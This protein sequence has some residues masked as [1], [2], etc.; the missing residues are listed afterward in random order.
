[1]PS[2]KKSIRELPFRP[3]IYEANFT[4][5][6]FTRD[7][8][9]KI[10]NQLINR[11]PQ[12]RFQ[13]LL[14]YESW[15]PGNWTSVGQPISLFTLTD[16]YDESQMPDGG[17]PETYEEFIVYITD[18]LLQ[19]GGSL[20]NSKRTNFIENN[21]CLYRCLYLA[22]G[23]KS[24]LPQGIKTPKILKKNLNL[25]RDDPI[26]INL[27]PQVE[28]LAGTITINVTGDYIYQ[29]NRKN[30]RTINLI[31]ANG[32]YSIAK[33]LDRKK[34]KAWYSVPKVP[35]IYEKNGVK[36]IV[37][38]FDGENHWNG[39]VKELNNYK[40]KRWSGKWC[41]VKKY[42]GLTLEETLNQFNLQ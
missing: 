33:N 40:F 31:L 41:L 19:V 34:F 23:T 5:K 15:K 6:N 37:T 16:H 42:D 11:Y 1:M 30:K 32:H 8:I 12:K 20:Y 7:N 25:K 13:V 2:Y 26:P 38:F 4:G 22:Y 36:N 14:P 39:T 21:D 28:G 17:D 35:L 3:G 18:P 24:R 29:S 10:T 9:N 27:I